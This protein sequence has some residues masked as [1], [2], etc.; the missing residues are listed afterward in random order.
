[1]ATYNQPIMIQKI[2]DDETWSDYHSCHA[3]I[4]KSNG[5]EYYNASTNIT[6]GTFNFKIRYCKKIDDIQYN[7]AMYRIIYKN[8]IFDI[9]NVDN[10]EMKNHDITIVGEFNNAVS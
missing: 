7:T 8:K 5:K 6:S 9:K 4:N 3:N 1:M 10:K 2:K